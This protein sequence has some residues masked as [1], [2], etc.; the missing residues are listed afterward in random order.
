MYCHD[1]TSEYKIQHR[2]RF[3]IFVKAII[4]TLVLEL[5]DV[6]ALDPTTIFCEHCS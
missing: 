6:L 5:N 4:I 1:H 2:Y 3:V